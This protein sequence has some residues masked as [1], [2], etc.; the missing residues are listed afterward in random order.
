[1]THI[2]TP[3]APDRTRIQCSWAFAP[4]DLDGAGFDPSYAVDFWDITNRQDW[5][6]CESVQRGISSSHYIPGVLSPDENGVYQLVTMPARG[7]R[8]QSLGSPSGS[9]V[10]PSAGR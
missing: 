2:L 9:P 8:G 5:A 4:E 10:T 7:Y 1:M 6:A 3:L